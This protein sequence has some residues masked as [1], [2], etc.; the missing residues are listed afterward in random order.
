M[1]NAISRLW[2]GLFGSASVGPADPV[3][4]FTDDSDAHVAAQD[5][6]PAV[7]VDGSP[8]IPGTGIDIHGHPYGVTDQ[9]TDHGSSA[10]GNSDSN[11]AQD[12]FGGGW[13]GSTDCSSSSS[14]PFNNDW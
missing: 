1:F 8:M 3:T 2:S 9:F 5:T 6:L 14:S 11:F 7:N 10:W 13:S 12:S 4:N